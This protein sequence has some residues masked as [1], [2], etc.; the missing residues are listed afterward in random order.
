MSGNMWFDILKE[1]DL[2]NQRVMEITKKSLEA[3]FTSV[4]LEENTS[5]AYKLAPEWDAESDYSF[6]I[7]AEKTYNES[8]IVLHLRFLYDM[9]ESKFIFCDVFINQSGGDWDRIKLENK[10]DLTDLINVVK[11]LDKQIKRHGR[12]SLMNT[13]DF[14]E[15]FW[16]GYDVV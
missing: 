5:S 9:D 8:S 15:I 13:L 11:E 6:Y 7:G 3:I 14:D 12:Y 2:Y 16:K 1:D 10:Y 4:I